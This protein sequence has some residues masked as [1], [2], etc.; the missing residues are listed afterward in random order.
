MLSPIGLLRSQPLNIGCLTRYAKGTGLSQKSRVGIGK[1]GTSLVS[2]CPRRPNKRFR[3]TRSRG[4][5]SGVRR[6]IKKCQKSRSHGRLMPGIPQVRLGRHW[7]L[8]SSDFRILYVTNLRCEDG[9]HLEGSVCGRRTH[10]KGSIMNYSL[11]CCVKGKCP[12]CIHNRGF[13]WC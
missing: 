11:Q 2:S 4:L 6:S 1:P 13:E 3:L 7:R 8:C 12:D 5:I 10:N 9:F